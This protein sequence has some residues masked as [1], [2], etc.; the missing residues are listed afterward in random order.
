MTPEEAKPYFQTRQLTDYREDW[1]NGQKGCLFFLGNDLNPDSDPSYELA[2]LDFFW[3]KNAKWEEYSTFLPYEKKIISTRDNNY[4]RWGLT[5]FSAVLVAY[6][7]EKGEPSEQDTQVLWNVY[8]QTRYDITES[9]LALEYFRFTKFNEKDFRSQIDDLL[10]L[11][12]EAS[13][14]KMPSGQKIYKLVE[15]A[16]IS[17]MDQICNDITPEKQL[18]NSTNIKFLVNKHCSTEVPIYDFQGEIIDFEQLEEDEKDQYEVGSITYTP[19]SVFARK[20]FFSEKLKISY[21]VPMGYDQ[22]K[23]EDIFDPETNRYDM[24]LL[25]DVSSLQNGIVFEEEL[26]T[27]LSEYLV[28]YSAM[29]MLIKAYKSQHSLKSAFD[30][31]YYTISLKLNQV[32]ISVCLDV[33][34]AYYKHFCDQYTNEHAKDSDF[35]VLSDKEKNSLLLD[36]AIETELDNINH[37]EGIHNYL[38]EKQSSQLR[39][40]VQNYIKYLKKLRQEITPTSQSTTLITSTPSPTSPTQ[41]SFDSVIQCAAPKSFLKLLHKRI[42]GSSPKDVGMILRRAIEDKS[43]SDIDK[44]LYESEFVQN[45]PKWDSIR[46]YITST[47]P[48][49]GYDKVVLQPQM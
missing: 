8:L 46:K 10:S 28:F 47:T 18:F 41:R 25:E 5:A 4:R 38:T 31:N 11:V 7:V 29:G 20:D 2:I 12:G 27:G 23:L 30:L 43:I 33:Y 36:K 48:P 15:T 13:R 44:Q 26:A 22:E 35:F 45:C 34:E 42:D 1:P 40:D 24:S 32:D 17:W 9:P 14:I 21:D 37:S 16:M 19:N 49:Y 6:C 39:K 3:R